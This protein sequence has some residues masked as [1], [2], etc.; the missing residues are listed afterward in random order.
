MEAQREVRKYL[1]ITKY[2]LPKLKGKIAAAATR[3]R[4][5]TFIISGACATTARTMDQID[6][7]QNQVTNMTPFSL[8]CGVCSICEAIPSTYQHPDPPLPHDDISRRVEPPSRTQGGH[9]G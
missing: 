3:H 7:N 9:D 5:Q 6:I 4:N 2:E 8:F 1:R